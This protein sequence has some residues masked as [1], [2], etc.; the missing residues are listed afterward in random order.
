[1]PWDQTFWIETI[2]QIQ[3]GLSTWLPA[4]LSALLL[5][6]VGWLVARISQAVVVRL[7]RKLGIDRLAERTGIDRGLTT[8][9][10]Q[11][12]LSYLL[13]RTT[14]W[15]ILIFFILLALGA[16]GLTEVVTSTLNSFFSFLPRLVA[17]TVIFLIGAFIARIVGDAITAATLQSNMSSGRIFGQAVRFCILLVVVILSLNELGVQTTILTTIIIITV[18]AVALGL[19]IAFGLGNRQ[20]AHSIMAGFHAREEFN[21]GQT[22]TIG[23]HTGRLV[24]IG[25]TKTLL[26]TGDGQISIPN[27]VLLNEMVQLSPEDEN[28]RTDEAQVVNESQEQPDP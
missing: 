6:L 4:I 25:T 16:L 18:A 26:Q 11:N 28:A 3:S 5:L 22:I 24:S 7:L 10:V 15:L 17:A 12:K 20:L 27:V 1:M 23:D 21:P 19:A 2:T 13:A 14:Y 8:I 9:G